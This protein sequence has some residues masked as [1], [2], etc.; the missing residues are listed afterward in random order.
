[1]RIFPDWLLL[2][3]A[4]LPLGS[5]AAVSVSSSKLADSNISITPTSKNFEISAVSQGRFVTSADGTQIF[6][7]A[8]GD[9]SKPA[10]VFIHGLGISA[11]SFDNVFNDPL[12]LRHVFLVR[13]DTRGHGRSDKPTTAAA[14]ESQR[15]AEDFDAV[16]R[17]YGLHR[18]FVLGWSYGATHITDIMTFH[19][20]NYL[21]GII[22][23]APQPR[24]T[25][26]VFSPAVAA[27]APGFTLTS[28]VTDFQATMIAFLNLCH[29]AL[30]WTFY[31]ACLGDALVQPRAVTEFLFSRTQSSD[32]LFKAGKEDGSLPLLAIFGGDDQNIVKDLVLEI[33][34]GWKDLSIV[35]IPGA[36]HFTFVSQ[37]ELFRKTVLNWVAGILSH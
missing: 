25:D 17:S 15:I 8:R 29:P 6:A 19:P 33:V 34:E 21:S 10:I 30:E 35:T 22:Y 3:T 24:T 12:W 11:M 13:Y 27:V 31:L 14:W 32:E 4:L 2:A 28:N 1:M 18:P 36:Q 37:P 9:P 23:D 16:V 20:A 5:L 7:D 26:F